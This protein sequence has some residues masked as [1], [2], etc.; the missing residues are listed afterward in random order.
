MK[1]NIN[2]LYLASPLFTMAADGES[3]AGV[4]CCVVFGVSSVCLAKCELACVLS[5]RAWEC[6]PT[7]M[8]RVF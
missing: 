5:V 1:R 8:D 4:C 3:A 2:D 7:E 6:R